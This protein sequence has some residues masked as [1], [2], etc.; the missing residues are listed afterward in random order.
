LVIRLGI[1]FDL[2]VFHDRRELTAIAPAP[3]S[4]SG[5]TRGD[6]PRVPLD[7]VRIMS[8]DCDTSTG[9]AVAEEQRKAVTASE[10][11]TGPIL[12]ERPSLGRNKSSTSGLHLRPVRR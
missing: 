2:L 6:P 9:G 8:G 12:C 1:F 4:D 11:P 7:F 3:P 5:H 10:Q